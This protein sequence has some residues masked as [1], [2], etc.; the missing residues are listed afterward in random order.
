MKKYIHCVWLAVLLLAFTGCDTGFGDSTDS[1]TKTIQWVYNKDGFFRFY[2]NES[3]FYGYAFFCLQSNNN[4]DQ[5][6][7]EI[8]IKKISGARGHGYGM[9]F[10]ALDSQNY[11]LVCIDGNNSYYVE[12]KVNGSVT[13]IKDW[14]TSS[15]LRTGFNVLNTIRVTKSGSTY[16]ISFNGNNAASFTDSSVNGSRMGG[17]AV[18]GKSEN[19]SFPGTPVEVKFR[20]TSQ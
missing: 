13:A 8:E 10:G 18:V 4:P 6:I 17:W 20:Q 9:V 1:S 2:T 3:K 7:Y 12:K 16:Q 5:N 11:Y 14:T 15:G 19:E